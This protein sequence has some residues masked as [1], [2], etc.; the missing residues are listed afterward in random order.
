[1][2]HGGSFPSD[3]LPNVGQDPVSFVFR[4]LSSGIRGMLRNAQGAGK[5]QLRTSRRNDIQQSDN[6]FTQ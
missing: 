5:V 3:R 2:G 6:H 4:G 1:M